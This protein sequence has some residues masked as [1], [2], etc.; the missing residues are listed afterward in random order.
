MTGASSINGLVFLFFGV[1][2]PHGILGEPGLGYIAQMTLVWLKE[3]LQRFLVRFA[4][5]RIAYGVDF[6]HSVGNAQ[7]SVY[8]CHKGDYLR[9]SHG[10]STAQHFRPE[11]MKLALSTLL[12]PLG[13]EHRDRCKTASVHRHAAP[14]GA[15]Q[16]KRC[17]R[18]RNLPVEA[19]T[20]RPP[21]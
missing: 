16:K 15:E 5:C 14:D 7:F 19:R 8:R 11:L 20:G 13:A 1:Q 10:I 18:C 17:Y 12:R 2:N 4:R 9:V 21:R 3:I 6:Q